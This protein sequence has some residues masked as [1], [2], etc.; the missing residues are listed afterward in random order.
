LAATSWNSM[1]RLNDW[2]GFGPEADS[3]E[4]RF[5]GT[6]RAWWLHST[7]LHSRDALWRRW[8]CD[9]LNTKN[10]LYT[11]RT[12]VYCPTKAWQLSTLMLSMKRRRPKSLPI[13][14]AAARVPSEGA[15]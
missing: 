6:K 3:D 15:I 13:F 2:F 5:A 10:V 7:F 12:T 9:P 11:I 14:V 8:R 1:I 4:K